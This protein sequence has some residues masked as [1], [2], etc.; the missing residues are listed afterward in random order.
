MT[1]V[2][3]KVWTTSILPLVFSSQEMRK[4]EKQRNLYSIACCNVVTQSVSKLSLLNIT[5]ITNIT[6]FHSISMWEWRLCAGTISQY[7]L[8]AQENSSKD[9]DIECERSVTIKKYQT[10]NSHSHFNCIFL[11]LFIGAHF[12]FQTVFFKCSSR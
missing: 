2:Y 10:P 3:G 9:G 7:L 8:F 12:G 4:N 6:R 5:N 11:L 1:P